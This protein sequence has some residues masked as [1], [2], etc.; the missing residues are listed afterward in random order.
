M[1]GLVLGVLL[2]TVDLGGLFSSGG[3]WSTTADDFAVEHAAD[4]FVF[5]SQKRD[6]VNCLRRGAATWLG[7]EVWETRVYFAPP[8]GAVRVELSLYNSGDRRAEDACG[9][10]DVERLVAEIDAAF[11]AGGKPPK[12]ERTKLKSGGSQLR[13]SWDRGE[14]AVELVWGVGDDQGEDVRF[15]RVTLKPH[16]EGRPRAIA[17]PLSGQA[18]AAKVKA[19]VKRNAEGDV[20]I[21]G[22]PMVD[23]GRKGYCAAAVSERVLRYYGHAVDEHEVAQQAGSEAEGGTRTSDMIETVKTLGSKYRL[24][25]NQLVSMSGTIGDLD[26]EIEQYN[27]AAKALKEEELSLQMFRRGNMIMVGDFYEAMKPKVLKRMRIKDARYKKFLLG[28][29]TQ[30]DKG[31]PLC[32][33]VTLG[34]YPEPGVN[35]QSRGGHMRLV[36]GYNAKTHEVLYTDTWGAG[37]ELKRMPEDWA[38]AI[39]HNLF[40]LRPL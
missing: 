33:G 27:K 18:A 10:T 26:K 37:H 31:V 39:T 19:N 29:K 30:V 2:A 24:G 28:V 8:G 21:D 34:I 9:K 5:A 6:I 3:A 25:F 20:W 4:G 15:V 7:H 35:I 17:K 14:P 1:T 22:V 40:F 36:I 38:F 23:Q 32:W 13:T 11:G 12:R 16:A